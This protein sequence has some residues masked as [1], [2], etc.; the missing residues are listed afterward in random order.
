MAKSGWAE[1]KMC[2]QKGEVRA[3]N[4]TKLFRLIVCYTLL[5]GIVSAGFTLCYKAQREAVTPYADAVVFSDES[6]HYFY[7][8]DSDIRT[9]N[10]RLVITG[11]V[12][13][14]NADLFYIKRKVLLVDEEHKVFAL[15]TIAVERGLTDFFNTGFQYDYGGLCA[16][17]PLKNIPHPG[18]YQI[19]FAAWDSDG[20]VRYFDVNAEVTV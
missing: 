14:K 4:E 3:V 2:Q 17:C 6:D 16:Q 9:D 10:G 1:R 19:V 7:G 12:T 11:W 20:G 18:T 5:C 8:C 13:D 15:P